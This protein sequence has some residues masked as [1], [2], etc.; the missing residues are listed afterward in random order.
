VD[1][2]RRLWIEMIDR[3]RGMALQGCRPSVALQGLALLARTREESSR[4]YLGVNCV[5]KPLSTGEQ[6]AS[7]GA[8]SGTQR[9]TL[10]TRASAGNVS[11]RM[12]D[13]L[14]RRAQARR[15]HR[16]SDSATQ[17]KGAKDRTA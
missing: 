15:S 8:G 17:A 10:I 13:E 6:L 1:A 2:W 16:T 4:G 11:P 5:T 14:A 7:L 12:R 9:T 3:A